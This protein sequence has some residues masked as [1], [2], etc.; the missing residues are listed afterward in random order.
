MTQILWLYYIRH[1]YTYTSITLTIILMDAQLHN[2]KNNTFNT[3]S[4]TF[5]QLQSDKAQILMA[6]SADDVTR[7]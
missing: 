4:H 2:S 3:R 7:H 1:L 5:T 6:P